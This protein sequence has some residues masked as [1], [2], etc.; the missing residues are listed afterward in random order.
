MPYTILHVESSPLGERSVSRKL[1]A[2]VLADLKAKHPDST[3]IER[4]L[5]VNPFPHL[6]GLTV[7][8]YF[9]PPEQRIGPLAEAIKPAD[10]QEARGPAAFRF[11]T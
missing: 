4:D 11:N 8:A 2:M 5:A 10:A 9:T 6:N 1:A 7:G 3:I